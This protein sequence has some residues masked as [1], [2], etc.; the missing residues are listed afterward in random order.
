MKS[1]S[2]RDICTP[3]FI[4]VLFTIAKI[5]KQL[6]GLLMDEWIKMWCV[7]VCV[8]T[9][10]HIYIYTHTYNGIL[11]SHEK[12]GILPFAITRM[13]LE[14]IVLSEISQI[15]KEKYC[16]ISLISRI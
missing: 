10:I 6:K 2:Q 3:T 4:A 11:F 15:E 7:C 1:G 16:M 13:D 5:G 8:C 9:Y 12:E 14:V